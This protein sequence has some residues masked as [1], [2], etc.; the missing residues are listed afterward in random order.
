MSDGKFVEIVQ[1]IANS[2]RPCLLVIAQFKRYYIMLK[3]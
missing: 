3:L 1:N 2:H